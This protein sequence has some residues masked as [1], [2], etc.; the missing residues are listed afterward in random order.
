MSLRE[1]NQWARLKQQH[2]PPLANR[3]GPTSQQQQQQDSDLG[4][5][6]TRG[7]HLDLGPPPADPQGRVDTSLSPREVDA[8]RRAAA[9]PAVFPRED[10]PCR[11]SFTVSAS[12]VGGT[13]GLAVKE[14]SPLFSRGGEDV[15]AHTASPAREKPQSPAEG[16]DREG[17]GVLRRHRSLVS[18]LVQESPSLLESGDPNWCVPAAQL[19]VIVPLF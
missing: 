7:N 12:W 1:R 5:Y 18:K 13:G 6:S 15:V 17:V 2:P 9:G 10:A 11:D 19:L 3:E 8:Q 16:Q 14:G 4:L